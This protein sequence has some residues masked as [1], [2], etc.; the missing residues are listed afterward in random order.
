MRGEPEPE[1]DVL[2]PSLHHVGRCKEKG[3]PH[4]IPAQVQD[5]ITPQTFNG[6][7]NE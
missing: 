4:E 6:E 7:E 1:R 3:D 2:S 5:T